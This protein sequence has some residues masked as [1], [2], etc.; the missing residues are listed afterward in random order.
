V[1]PHDPHSSLTDNFC[2]DDNAENW[3]PDNAAE[4]ANAEVSKEDM[5][6]AGYDSEYSD[7]DEYKWKAIRKPRLPS[8]SSE[9]IDYTPQNGTRLAD[10]FRESGLQVI[11]KMASIELTPEKPEFP[12]GGWHVEGQMNE[13]ICGTALYYLDS[14]NITESSL[15]FRMQTSAYLSDDDGWNVGQDSYHWLQSAYGTHFGSGNSPCLQNYGSIVTQQGRLLAFPNVFQHRVSSFKL[16]DPTKP[17][18]RRFI[19]LWLVDPNLRIIST[20]NVPPQQ[21]SW[22]AEA[23]LGRTPEAQ[24]AN[25]TKLPAEVIALLQ[26]KG[27]GPAEFGEGIALSDGLR[28]PAELMDIVRDYFNADG[29][30]MPMSIEEAREHREKL[31]AE[32]GAFRDTAGEGWHAH[33]YSFCE[34]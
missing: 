29:A 10:R 9:K 15:S 6:E 31:M 16:V 33:S 19:A 17:G 24:R 7:E 22:Y 5:E 21:M 23:L 12:A 3:I 1:Y 30:A 14:E 27:F 25:L 2:S 11:V 8:A 20:A 34:H 18:H 4:C 26:E 28:L 13:H 32:R